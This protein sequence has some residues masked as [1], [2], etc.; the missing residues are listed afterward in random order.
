MRRWLPILFAC[1]ASVCVSPP[2]HAD[3]VLHELDRARRAYEQRDF[4]AA[5]DVADTVIKLIRQAQAEAWKVLLPDPLPGWTADEAQSTSVAPVFFGGGR[6]T[7][8]VYRRGTD[9]VE[10]AVIASSPLIL[11]GLAPLLASGLISGGETNHNKLSL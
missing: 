6:S 11:Q 4:T 8:R 2:T 1:I 7:S 3:D 5:A 9:T 10:I